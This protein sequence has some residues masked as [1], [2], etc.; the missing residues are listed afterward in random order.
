MNQVLEILR[1]GWRTLS[2]SCRKTTVFYSSGLVITTGLDG[3]ALVLVARL[4]E[5]RNEYS[6][7]VSIGYIAVIAGT[8]A[9]LFIVRSLAA[10]TI[11]WVST[12]RLAK[13]E[14]SVGSANFEKYIKESWEVSQETSVTQVQTWVDR[15]PWALI[16]GV[17]FY[18]A[19]LCAEIA[20][21]L[22]IFVVLL[23]LQPVTA[24]TA[25]LYFFAVAFFQH[26]V[27]SVASQRAGRDIHEYGNSVYELIND[28]YS[29]RKVLAVSPSNSL[30]KV[31]E[32]ERTK[33]ALSRA[34]L[35][36]L[37]SLPRYFMEASLAIGFVF[38]GSATYLLNGVDAVVPALTVFAAAGFRLLP[39]V[40]RI[41]GL[42]LAV[43]GRISL[44]EVTLDYLEAQPA[45]ATNKPQLKTL[46]I[47]A[48]EFAV[49]LRDVSYKYPGDG[50]VALNEISFDFEFGM[51]YAIVGPSGSGKTTLVEICL[52]L[53]QPKLGNIRISE[54]ASKLGYVPQ[55]THLAGIPIANNIALEWDSGEIDI[56]KLR[57]VLGD[58]ELEIDLSG[59]DLTESFEGMSGGQTQRLGLARALY[60][61]PNFLVLDEATN[62]LDAITEASV[63]E[64]IC[65][66]RGSVT[67]LLV[68][69][70]LTTVQKS[71]VIIYMDKGRILAAGAFGEI[72]RNVPEFAK[73][74][75]L[76]KLEFE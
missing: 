46:G 6:G 56:S 44:S 32:A 35:L 24:L 74:V 3:L 5:E 52:G 68:A 67:V 40:N 48:K 22:V 28:S 19:S 55:Q 43:V 10:V 63:M 45:P 73:Q 59:R 25:A 13:E 57:A 7:D 38:I 49:S 9:G 69:H 72:Y 14:V 1:R 65:A 53:R 75:D 39:I 64:S 62:A 50:V 70:R 71:D 20:S 2:K 16:S 21:A 54:V 31:V 11:S 66:L 26:R 17:V 27:L 30:A 37:E 18:V 41:Q 61:N 8:V 60:R 42:V 4:L 76:G 47:A 51:Q 58:S 15:G 12:I 33:Y 29:L 23:V 36:F 34:K